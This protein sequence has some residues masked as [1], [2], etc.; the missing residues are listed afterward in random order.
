MSWGAMGGLGQA[1]TNMAANMAEMDKAKLRDKLETD[2]E[3]A[4]EAREAAKLKRTTSYRK[5]T[6][7]KWQSYNADDEL[8]RET[9]ATP[10]EI[11]KA[12]QEA[13]MA[14]LDLRSKKAT[15]ETS[16]TELAWAKEDRNLLNPEQRALS[17]KIK[18]GLALSAAE[19]EQARRWGLEF[20][21]R[22]RHH[23][24][25]VKLRRSGIEA[26]LSDDTDSGQAESVEAA[27]KQAREAGLPEAII[28][29]LRNQAAS[30]PVTRNIPKGGTI[31]IKPSPEQANIA[32]IEL[33]NKELQKSYGAGNKGLI[34]GK[35]GAV[36]TE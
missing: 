30:T 22:E 23:A 14:A 31:N 1:F 4:R 5:L 9:A 15:T 32:F 2:R 35:P 6:N 19:Q 3:I 36:E 21:Q 28:Q 34:R 13:D 25:D 27:V 12:K 24:D 7:G 29:R 20:N 16:E 26:R 10:E 8:L 11:A 33:L 18:A 17:A